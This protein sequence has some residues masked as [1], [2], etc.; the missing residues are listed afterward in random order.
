MRLQR[1]SLIDR[2][3]LTGCVAATRKQLPESAQNSYLLSPDVRY[4]IQS[5][6]D[7]ENDSAANAPFVGLPCVIARP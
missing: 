1:R 4:V 6:F 5:R 3:R 7:A 2:S